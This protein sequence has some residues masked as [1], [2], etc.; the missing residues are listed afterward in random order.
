ML[1]IWVEC[2]NAFL[3]VHRQIASPLD[4]SPTWRPSLLW[5]NDYLGRGTPRFFADRFQTSARVKGETIY[6]LRLLQFIGVFGRHGARVLG[7][8]QNGRG[9]DPVGNPIATIPVGV[10]TLLANFV[11]V[12]I[13]LT[14]RN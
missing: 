8:I 9:A 12:D 1:Y 11:P 4:D 5:D 7:R 2:V 3:C 10:G 14:I 6:V 13:D